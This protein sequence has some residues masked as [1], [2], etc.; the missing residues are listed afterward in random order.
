MNRSNSGFTA[1]SSVDTAYHEG[2]VFQAADMTASLKAP[3]AIG[4]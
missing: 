1:R 2:M 4:F 3:A